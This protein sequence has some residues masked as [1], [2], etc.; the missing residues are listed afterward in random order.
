MNCSANEPWF[1]T[2]GVYLISDLISARVSLIISIS[3]VF[4]SL[5]FYLYVDAI[6]GSFLLIILS[7][8]MLLLAFLAN[9]F[10]IILSYFSFIKCFL[11]YGI[12]PAYIEN[13]SFDLGVCYNESISSYMLRSGKLF[14]F[15][16]SLFTMLKVDSLSNWGL[17]LFLFIASIYLTSIVELFC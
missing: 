17:S 3:I 16:V 1:V 6:S 8:D 14:T 10:L 7:F 12:S 5:L 13:T 4:V 11:V 15:S 9:I 2:I